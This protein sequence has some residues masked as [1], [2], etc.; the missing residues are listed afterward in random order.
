MELQVGQ[1]LGSEAKYW[2]IN[3]QGTDLYLPRYAPPVEELLQRG[4]DVSTIAPG[5]RHNLRLPMDHLDA[6]I[7]FDTSLLQFAKY[8]V[9]G[10]KE[11]ADKGKINPINLRVKLV[12][13]KLFVAEHT[14]E[15]GLFVVAMFLGESLRFVKA[16][17]SVVT[18]EPKR[19]AG[20][21]C[22][23]T[24]AAEARIYLSNSRKA[25]RDADA[26]DKRDVYRPAI[27][28]PV[29]WEDTTLNEV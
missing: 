22:V 15:F 20:E 1:Q 19:D 8:T 28:V 3:E 16:N 29:R 12:S 10:Y 17:N 18:R 23:T 2:V 4:L 7:R 9:D 6:A 5:F 26:I 24:S 25:R 13:K 14:Q 21:L 27:I 11:A